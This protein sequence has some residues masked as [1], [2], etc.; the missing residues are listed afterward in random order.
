MYGL[1][2]LRRGKAMAT[3]RVDRGNATLDE[4]DTTRNEVIHL[5]ESLCK[6]HRLT[7][8][9]SY[10]AETIA[11]SH[12]FDASYPTLI[13]LAELNYGTLKPEQVKLYREE[14]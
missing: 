2:L 3:K 14:G 4:G 8:R 5:L 1:C 12:G 6:S 10:G 13:T 7:M 11:A 9:S